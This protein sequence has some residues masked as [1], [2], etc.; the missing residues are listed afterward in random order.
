MAQERTLLTPILASLGFA[1]DEDQPHIGGERY[2]MQSVTTKSGRKLILL[3]THTDS[4][5]RVVIKATRDSAGQA[6]LRHERICRLAMNSMPFA[7]QKFLHPEELYFG[8]KSGFVISIQRY[9]EQSSPFLGRPIREQFNYALGALKAQE[10]SHAA[11]YE[12]IRTIRTTFGTSNAASYVSRA[13]GFARNIAR[14][15]GNSQTILLEVA[16]EMLQTVEQS[17]ERIEQYGNF[18]THTDFVPH[19]F[20]I[21]DGNFY[22]LD[23]SSLRFGNKHEGWARFLNFMLIHN[24]EL[25]GAFLKYFADNRAPEEQESLRIMRIYRLGEIILYYLQT[26]PKSEGG[27]KALNSAR[28]DFW[29]AVLRAQLDRTPLPDAVRIEYIQTRNSLRSEEEN[30]RQHDLH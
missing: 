21:Q 23:Y 18:L 1:L 25:E 30:V 29:A 19:N 17:T 8:E 6:E 15:A 13:R 16:A 5:D 2:L 27:L 22:L 26:L 3:G 7:Y 24:P 20:R 10:S 4:G 28:A 9:I 11:T 14:N 12:Q